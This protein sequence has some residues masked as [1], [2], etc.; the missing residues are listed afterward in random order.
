MKTIDA[1]VRGYK[2]RKNRL[3]NV[4]YVLKNILTQNNINLI[5]YVDDGRVN[6]SFHEKKIIDLIKQNFD[7][8]RI[9]IPKQR[10]WYDILIYDYRKKWIP[11]NIKSSTCKNNDNVGN[12][13]LCLYAYTNIEMDFDKNYQNSFCL[14]HLT[15]SKN[16]TGRDY[17]FLVL[18]KLDQSVIINS[19]LG[20][21]TISKNKCNL[22]FQIKWSRNNEYKYNTPSYHFKQFKSFYPTLFKATHA[23]YFTTD[24]NLKNQIFQMIL[25]R[26]ENILEPSVGRGDLVKFIKRQNEHLS[27]DTF[28]IDK[29]IE[30]VIDMPNTVFCDFLNQDFGDKTWTTIIGNPPY[31]KQQKHNKNLYIQF[32]EKCFHLLDDNGELVFIIPS[33]FFKQTSASELIKEMMSMGTF[34]HIYHPNDE[35]LFA[36]ASIDVLVFRYCKNKLLDNNVYFNGKQ[37]FL[38]HFNGMIKFQTCK[39]KGTRISSLFSIHV[40]IV[41]GLDKVFKQDFGNIEILYDDNIYKRFICIN[42][43]PHTDDKI[44]EFLLENKKQLLERRIMKMTEKNWFK[45]GALRNCKIINE[46]KNR[47]CIYIKTLTRNE[48]VAFIGKVGYFGGNLLLMLPR[49]TDINLQQIV[50]KLN[51]SEF[52]N[53]FLYTK[54]FKIGH[55]QLSDSFI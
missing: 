8:K 4:M 1:L 3:P 39:S 42:I 43:F 26:P 55:K 50:D 34:T 18:N 12:M 5:N 52:K 25:N 15:D 19:L 53:D 45:W 47:D 2:Y 7:E 21:T 14:K 32:I 28:E 29:T 40:G 27:F 38:N 35:N 30:T 49:S 11:V 37:L 24:S 41:S 44:N 36:N 51:N 31:S 16:T 13:A 10:A 20:L 22:P 9:K 33:D 46:N 17:Y 54:R 48:K 6:S 23:Q